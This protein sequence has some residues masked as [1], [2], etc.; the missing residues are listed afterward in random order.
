MKRNYRLSSYYLATFIIISLVIC[1][2]PALAGVSTV[3]YPDDLNRT[4]KSTYSPIRTTAETSDY[5]AIVTLG[6][7]DKRGVHSTFV[8]S[9]VNKGQ[10]N[11]TVDWNRIMFVQGNATSGGIVREGVPFIAMN[12]PQQPDMIFPGGSISK[13]VVPKKLIYF[14]SE[15]N[16]GW[17][18]D[19]L[20]GDVGL[21]L[22]L[23]VGDDVA[24]ERL[25]MHV[26]HKEVF[27]NYAK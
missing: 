9:V 8:V 20:S 25:M 18:L 7:P 19:D 16:V 14:V 22:P 3:L 17:V 12:A 2:V 1:A 6:A 4:Y 27:K 15:R 10:K 13:A 21:Y 26:E 11:I 23:V 5:A 24:E